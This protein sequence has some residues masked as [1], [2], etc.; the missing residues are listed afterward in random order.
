METGKK[1]DSDVLVRLKT[2]EVYMTKSNSDFENLV[3]RKVNILNSINPTNQIV[4]M[5]SRN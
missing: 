1:H 5:H 3:L 4:I 2:G